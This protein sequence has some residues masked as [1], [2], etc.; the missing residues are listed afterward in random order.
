MGQDIINIYDKHISRHN[1]TQQIIDILN[2][3][4]SKNDSDVHVLFFTFLTWGWTHSGIGQ[5]YLE[6]KSCVEDTCKL[7]V[8]DRM[9]DI[10]PR[11]VPDVD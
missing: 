9:E 3:L 6:F 4:T 2:F 5:L 10:V 11:P 7:C 1:G 8:E